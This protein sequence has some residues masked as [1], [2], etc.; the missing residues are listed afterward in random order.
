MYG[1]G[2]FA[3]WLSSGLLPE[4]PQRNAGRDWEGQEVP[5]V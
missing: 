3:K 5:F 1:D 2:T 4:M